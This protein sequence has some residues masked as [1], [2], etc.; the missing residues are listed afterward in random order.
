[1]GSDVAENLSSTYN[2]TKGA[3]G[4][5]ANDAINQVNQGYTKSNSDL[6]NQVAADPTAAAGNADTLS[7]F[8]GQLNNTYTGPTSWADQGNLQGQVAQAQQYGGLNKTPGGLNVLTQQLE[9]PQASQGVNQLDTMLLGGNPGAMQQVNAASDPYATLNGYLD[10]QGAGVTSAIGQGQ[11]TA[12]DTSAN[13]LGAFT[14]ANGTL[15]NLNSQIGNE[16]STAQGGFD[17]ATAANKALASGINS[18]TLTPEQ[19]ASLGVTPDQ[20]SALNAAQ[21]RANTSQYMTGHNFGAASDVGQIDLNP[22]LTQNAGTGPQAGTVATPQEYAQMSAIQKL[23]GG[24]NPTGNAINP[25][26]AS[27]AGTYNPSGV[28]SKFDYAGAL[29]GATGLG[30]QERQAAQ[31][32]ANQL[33]GAADAAHNA[34][35]PRGFGGFVKAAPL[36]IAPGVYNAFQKKG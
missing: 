5:S 17:T 11:Q 15:T 30:D 32:Q 6:I 23:L 7:Q 3:I 18:G 14:G 22:F 1:L 4:Q 16:L 36:G 24:Q 26:L 34:G 31:D 12:K 8:Q 9:G 19:V 29:A 35:K 2:Q 27:L 20:Y 21:T 13:A 25:A 33:S 28:N 10:S